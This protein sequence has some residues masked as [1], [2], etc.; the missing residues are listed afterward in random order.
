M[1]HI[2]KKIKKKSLKYQFKKIT[3]EIMALKF[4]CLQCYINVCSKI[5]RIEFNVG[6]FL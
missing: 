1:P 2:Y 3:F 4:V 6:M 5:E